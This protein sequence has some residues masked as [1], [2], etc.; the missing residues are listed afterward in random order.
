[1]QREMRLPARPG[2]VAA[3]AL[4]GLLLMAAF[5]G[6]TDN[7]TWDPSFY[8]AHIRSPVV[9]G[10]LDF[11]DET[12]TGSVELPRT[13][14]GL[15]DS[16]WPIG[17]SLLWSPYLLA[18]HGLMLALR[19]GAADGFA[20]LYIAL[21]TAGSFGYGLAGLALIY[22]L[23][24]GFGGRAAAL[25]VTALCLG[26]TP[27][28]F[29]MFRQPLMAHTTGLT[30]AAALVLIYLRLSARPA[31]SPQSGLLFGVALG[32]CFLTR[33]NGLLMAIVP[34]FYFGEQLWRALARRAW[35]EAGRVLL[36]A[37][38]ALGFFLLTLTPQLALWYRLHGRIAVLPQGG[39]SFVDSLLPLNL[40]RVF[41]ATNRG[42]LFWCP[43]ALLGVLGIACIPDK[44]LRLMAALVTLAQALLV[45]YRV[46]WYSGGGFGAR[47]FIEL[48]PFLAVG[49]V[50]L[51]GRL[52]RG[53]GWAV[54]AGL[55]GAAMVL[56]QLA[57]MHAYE[58]GTEGW[59][60]MAAY[61]L[62]LPL[63]V[64]WQLEALG[65]LARSPWLWLDLRPEVAADRQAI[66]ANL[67]AG[68]RDPRSYVV[69]GLALA[70]APLVALLVA[71]AGAA[72]RRGRG[73]ALLLA[74]ALYFAAWGGVLLAVG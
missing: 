47:Y 3:L 67:R 36:Q 43:F 68:V 1:M 59:L 5:F 74:V 63:G 14:T 29:Y 31:L 7:W 8:Y 51:L 24:R 19:P 11:S 21:V 38:L 18:A 57:L 30:A 46:D 37:A 60:D 15:Q 53:R 4:L 56:H 39:E 45:G 62:G 10:D 32:L 28:F 66:L 58:H 52:P 16:A 2:V 34:A 35:P 6:P 12:R 72:A 41:L 65:R 20:P 42:L 70:A 71:A 50:C 26:A 25:G 22:Q 17:P 23:C 49:V 9:D 64:G 40:P 69:T 54:G 13:A 48:L 73:A 33:W 61:N 44:R 55:C 27:L